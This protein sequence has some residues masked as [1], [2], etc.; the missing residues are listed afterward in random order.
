MVD[1][2]DK[3]DTYSSNKQVTMQDFEKFLKEEQNDL[4]ASNKEDIRNFMCDFLK[5]P[6]RYG[7][8]D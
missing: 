1:I 2:F 8:A 5:D 4:L 7:I 6:H 3:I